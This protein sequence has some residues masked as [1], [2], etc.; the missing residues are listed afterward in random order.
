MGID[1]D[2][3][4]ERDIGL[5]PL[6]RVKFI[7]IGCRWEPYSIS[8]WKQSQSPQTGQVYF[9][10]QQEENNGYADWS[11]SPQTGQV[12]FNAIP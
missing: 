10:L 8:I 5:N 9:N 3:Y 11:Q 4:I 6:K 2:C 1:V 12:Y 7:S